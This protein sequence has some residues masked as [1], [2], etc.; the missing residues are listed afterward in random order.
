MDLGQLEAFIQVA[1]Q[2]SFSR[3]AET[4]QLTQ[5]SI[6]ARIQALERELGGIG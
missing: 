5:P 3:A 2:S 6:T 4:L 1:T